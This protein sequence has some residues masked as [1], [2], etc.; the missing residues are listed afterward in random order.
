MM[1]Y[2]PGGTFFLLVASLGAGLVAPEQLESCPVRLA[3]I[4]QL[5]G[6]GAD[7]DGRRVLGYQALMKSTAEHL[8]GLILHRPQGRHHSPGAR[9]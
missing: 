2:A 6:G 4:T 1:L 7:G 8:R 3:I 5:H 9:P